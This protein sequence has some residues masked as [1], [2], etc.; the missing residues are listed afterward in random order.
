MKIKAAAIALACTIVFLTGCDSRNNSSLPESTTSATDT[1][2]TTTAATTEITTAKTMSEA[3]KQLLDYCNTEAESYLEKI[4]GYY[5]KTDISAS[6]PYEFFKDI[7]IESYTCGNAVPNTIINDGIEYTTGYSYDV[8]LEIFESDD[9]AFPV[10]TS[11][12][13]LEAGPDEVSWINLFARKG[14]RIDRLTSVRENSRDAA[15]FCYFFTKQFGV[16]ES[17]T[18]MQTIVPTVNSNGEFDNFVYSCCVFS[19]WDNNGSNQNLDADYI[20][21][22]I[23][24]LLGIDADL[25]A[26]KYYEPDTNILNFPAH[27]GRWYYCAVNSDEYDELN[28]THTVT[29]DFYAD[30]AYLVKARSIKFTVEGKTDKDFKLISTEVTFDSGYKIAM[31]SI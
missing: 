27:G 14:I 30:T 22:I 28:N 24:K 17:I 26:S 10:R 25:K 5:G 4:K 1:A 12:W 7:K 13:T 11:E 20:Q 9:D 16:P 6:D 21:G 3:D 23:N 8:I 2:A 19:F 15:E 29:I 18:D 31:G